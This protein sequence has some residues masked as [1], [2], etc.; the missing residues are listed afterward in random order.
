MSIEQRVQ[1]LEDRAAIAELMHAYCRLADQ[2]DAPAMMETFTED[3]IASYVEGQPPLQ[4]RAAVRAA[5]A[6]FLE[7]VVGGS[8]YIANLEL[9]FESDDRVAGAMYMY[10]WQR[11]RVSGITADCHRWGRY[12]ARFERTEAGWKISCLRLLSALEHGG[13]RLVEYLNRPFPPHFKD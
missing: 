4:G 7:C 12:E 11:F 3:C 5:L 6:G 13:S 10:S 2:L 1:R 9:V 8:H